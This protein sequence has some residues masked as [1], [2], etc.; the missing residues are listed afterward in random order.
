MLQCVTNYFWGKNIMLRSKEEILEILEKK[1]FSTDLI[2]K[3]LHEQLLSPMPTGGTKAFGVMAVKQLIPSFL[4][5]MCP[6]KELKEKIE[7]ESLSEHDAQ[8]ALDLEKKQKTIEYTLIAAEILALYRDD[9]NAMEYVLK[10]HTELLSEYGVEALSYENMGLLFSDQE[11]VLFDREQAY[12]C[13]SMLLNMGEGAGN[14][15]HPDVLF[16]FANSLPGS[17]SLKD[18]MSIYKKAA[19]KGHEKA[20]VE[21]QNICRYSK[22]CTNCGGNFKGIFVKKCVSCGKKKD[23]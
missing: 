2:A 12:K 3:N 8:V 13:F 19:D 14:F 10:W 6:T 11:C 22:L 20:K 7:K 15:E 18:A 4:E 9:Y 21:F 23:Y 16:A 1:D 17:W 5:K